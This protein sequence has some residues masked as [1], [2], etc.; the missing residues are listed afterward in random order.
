MAEQL[1]WTTMWVNS[2]DRLDWKRRVEEVFDIPGVE[3]VVADDR[4]G[5]VRVRY[6]PEAVT[7]FQL[8]SHLRAAGL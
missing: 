4:S 8:N 6:N 3:K 1:L 7:S 2:I 5:Q